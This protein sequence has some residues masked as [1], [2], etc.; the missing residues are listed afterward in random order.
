MLSRNYEIEYNVTR[1]LFKVYWYV[2]NFVILY[3]NITIIMN[4]EHD[5][6]FYVHLER[7]TIK[8]VAWCYR[9]WE[10]FLLSCIHG[11]IKPTIHILGYR[12]LKQPQISFFSW[13]EWFITC[14]AQDDFL[15]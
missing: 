8:F 4:I 7:Y 15:I 3:F 12:C 9:W 11:Q 5:I 6:M 1:S 10:W 2:N 13:K 14:P